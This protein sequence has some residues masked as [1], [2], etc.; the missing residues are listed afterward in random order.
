MTAPTLADAVQMWTLR[1]RLGSHAA[2]LDKL[3]RSCERH[4]EYIGGGNALRRYCA[5]LRQDLRRAERITL[6]D[7]FA[8][9]VVQ[10]SAPGGT[11]NKDLIERALGLARAPFPVT[12]LEWNASAVFAEQRIQ[13][14]LADAD[15]VTRPPRLGYLIRASEDGARWKGGEW[16]DTP[17]DRSWSDAPQPAL[18]VTGISTEPLSSSHPHL[19]RTPS[20]TRINVNSILNRAI[21]LAG[22]R[23]LGTAMGVDGEGYEQ[24]KWS[25]LNQV[26][27]DFDEASF[28]MIFDATARARNPREAEGLLLANIE[29]DVAELSGSLRF[30]VFALALINCAAIE[31]TYTAA[32]AGRAISGGRSVPYL[33]H[34]TVNIRVPAGVRTVT[35]Y[36]TQAIAQAHRRAHRVRGHWRAPH[37]WRGQPRPGAWV[38]PHTR[39]DAS[40]GLIDQD[41]LVTT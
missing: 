32:P 9:Q 2:D 39:G 29:Y 21:L 31:Y 24:A 27:V 30:V 28:A 33:A 41:H 5:T 8:R 14:T 3:A 4:P 13:G 15:P 6:S 19:R 1:P 26:A 18:I 17:P 12:W 40:L 16:A 34:R 23:S 7:D 35:C 11:V 38:K 10:L 25:P 37:I 22:V 36:L 20:G